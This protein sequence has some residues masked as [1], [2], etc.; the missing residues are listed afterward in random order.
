MIRVLHLATMPLPMPLG[1][2]VYI[3]GLVRALSRRGLKITLGCVKGNGPVQW[4]GVE[5]IIP[6]ISLISGSGP[7]WARPLQDFGLLKKIRRLDVEIVHAHHVESPWIARMAFGR[8]MP[9][10]HHLHTRLEQELPAWWGWGKWAGKAVDRMVPAISDANIAISSA[11]EAHFRR[12]RARRVST[13]LPGIDP[14]D[15]EGAESERGRRS[16]ALDGR[17]WLIYAGNTDPYQSLER[18]PSILQ[19]VPEAGLIVLATDEGRSLRDWVHHL[20]ANRLRVRTRAIWP[21][22]RDALAAADLAVLPREHCAGFPMKLLNQLALGL[23]TVGLSAACPDLPGT[24]RVP[25]IDGFAGA[26]RALLSDEERRTRL[27]REAREAMREHTW[28]ARAAEV[29]AL[30]RELLQGS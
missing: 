19:A 18:L 5:T 8:S 16:L 21:D 26:I 24:V 1:S 14:T 20:P 6:D 2:P 30:Y 17:H 12:I 9:V 13:I 3:G 15:L 23:P 7:H 22:V 28:D 11:S 29:E 27:S 4:E 10:I 25:T